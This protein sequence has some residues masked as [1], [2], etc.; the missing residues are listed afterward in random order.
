MNRHTAERIKDIDE[1]IAVNAGVQ[2]V[3]M[4]KYNQDESVDAWLAYARRYAMPT[5]LATGGE[6]Y[7]VH[8]PDFV[9]WSEENPEATRTKHVATRNYNLLEVHG[10]IVGFSILG[11]EML[12]CCLLGGHAAMVSVRDGEATV[13]TDAPQHLWSEEVKAEVQHACL[14]VDFL[15]AYIAASTVEVVERKPKMGVLAKAG[16]KKKAKPPTK[17]TYKVIRAV[18][19][20]YVGERLAEYL[21]RADPEFKVPVRGTWRKV[22]GIGKDEQGQPVL[23]KT[24]VVPHVRF[25]D[26]P[27]GPKVVW[28]KEPLRGVGEVS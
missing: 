1:E 23:G 20:I 26:K 13:L 19:K 27:D 6:N 18:R 25:K 16:F 28:V 17:V 3:L 11:N 14:F 2:K 24:W 15:P 9:M 5:K 7:L 22:K 12:V 10:S 8:V 21:R 4:G